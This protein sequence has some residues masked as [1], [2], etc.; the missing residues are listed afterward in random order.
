MIWQGNLAG[1]LAYQLFISPSYSVVLHH[2]ASPLILV[3]SLITIA[4]GDC[5]KIALV[6]FAREALKKWPLKQQ[7]RQHRVT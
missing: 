7:T 2:M 6:T 5:A 4:S 3:L 1:W